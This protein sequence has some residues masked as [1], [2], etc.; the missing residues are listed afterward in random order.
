MTH[1]HNRGV[2]S[3]EF[4]FGWVYI[5]VIIIKHSFYIKMEI[6]NI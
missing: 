2:E 4:K 5:E 1:K 6:S 3:W